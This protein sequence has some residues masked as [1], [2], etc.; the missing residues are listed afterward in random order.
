M[1]TPAYR[2]LLQTPD[3]MAAIADAAQ[4]APKGKRHG[5]GMAYAVL[6]FFGTG[7]S[8]CG[9]VGLTDRTSRELALQLLTYSFPAAVLGGAGSL[10][11]AS[12]SIDARD[13][14]EALGIHINDIPL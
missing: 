7:F 5:L 14:A 3:A 6:L 9:L 10:K 4:Y 11:E 12:K 2:D 1:T 8:L 13:R